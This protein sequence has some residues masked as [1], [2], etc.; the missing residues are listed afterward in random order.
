MTP[1]QKRLVR[2]L[3]RL[4]VRCADVSQKVDRRDPASDDRLSK[5][6]LEAMA[7]L[8]IRVASY[9]EKGS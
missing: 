5:A 7:M 1:L 4:A 6:D 3:N 9:I 8:M 2:N